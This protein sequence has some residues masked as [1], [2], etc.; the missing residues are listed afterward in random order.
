[1]QLVQGKA[2]SQPVGSRLSLL[3]KAT[4]LDCVQGSLMLAKSLGSSDEEGYIW[5]SRFV[6]IALFF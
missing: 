4:R 1:M 2:P 3:G 6:S 5:C